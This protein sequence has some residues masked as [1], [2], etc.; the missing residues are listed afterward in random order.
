MEVN[1]IVVFIPYD[2]YGR[3]VSVEERVMEIRFPRSTSPVGYDTFHCVIDIEDIEIIS[4][5]FSG[6]V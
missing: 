4:D 2:V 1:N 6:D 3:I 5:I